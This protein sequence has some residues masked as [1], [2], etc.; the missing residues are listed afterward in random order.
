MPLRVRA[1]SRRVRMGRTIATVL[2]GGWRA[3]RA[4]DDVHVSPICVEQLLRTGCAAIAWSR[5]RDT[6][7]GK[8]ATL[9]TLR[10]AT[11]IY[12]LQA[13]LSSRQLAQLAHVL[14]SAGVDALLFK[15][16]TA[17]RLY[18]EPALRPFGDVD[19]WVRPTHRNSALEV[20][21]ALAGDD[22]CSVDLHISFP[23]LPDRP[24]D[25]VLRRSRLVAV[26]EQAQ[27]RSLC[28]EDHLRCLTVHFFRHGA[29]RPLSLC[30]IGAAMESSSSDFDWDHC[31]R[32]D[33]LL[34]DYVVL[35]MKL[36]SGLLGARLPAS[37]PRM[38]D[39]SLPR[40][41]T[42]A[43]LRQWGSRSYD[44]CVN[45]PLMECLRRRG[46][47]VPALRRRWPSAVQL[48]VDRHA[49]IGVLPPLWLQVETVV[50]QALGFARRS[51]PV[52]A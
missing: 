10:Q 28:P 40:W 46:E 36:A 2:H 35:A 7:S 1:Q 17:A 24:P 29:T 8:G 26:G 15:G 23:D 52:L 13:A 25:E 11:Q 38:D 3:A 45:R 37:A 4:D 51:V 44:T 32:G 18:D 50:S 5:M 19:L 31:L 48:T 39:R 30:D 49:P 47:I 42:R 34:T 20:V 14:R 27:I 21:R 33:T 22:R 16:W 9:E 43:V 12:A 6:P 41:L